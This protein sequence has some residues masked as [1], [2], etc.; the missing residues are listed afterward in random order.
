M[1]LLSFYSRVVNIVQ[2]RDGWVD[3]V[4]LDLKSVSQSTTLKIAMEDKKL[5]KNWRKTT[6]VD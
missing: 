3:G 4:Y 1:N 6:G 5:W 2:E